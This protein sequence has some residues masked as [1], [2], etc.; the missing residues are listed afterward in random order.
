[1]EEASAGGQGWGSAGVRRWADVC[2]A[3]EALLSAC[4][5]Y[6]WWGRLLGA[7][8]RSTTHHQRC[9][10]VVR[11]GECCV[12]RLTAPCLHDAAMINGRAGYSGPVLCHGGCSDTLVR[13]GLAS[14]LLLPSGWVIGAISMPVY[15]Y[16]AC[17]TMLQRQ[18]QQVCVG[19]SARTSVPLC[20]WLRGGRLG[21]CK[22]RAAHEAFAICWPHSVAAAAGATGAGVYV[23]T[24]LNFRRYT[25]GSWC[26][27]HCSLR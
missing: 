15:H 4:C 18:G 13:W 17:F 3:G 16:A 9:K 2:G 23:C 22:V 27:V 19:A 14:N 24:C 7:K 5:Y 20:G 26:L 21:P 11:G 12:R 25:L 1:M 10:A 6:H 8:R